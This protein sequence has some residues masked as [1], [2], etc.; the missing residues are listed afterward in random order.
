VRCDV[1]AMS[2]TKGPTMSDKPDSVESGSGERECPACGGD[3]Y[4]QPC[5]TC[6]SG[7]LPTVSEPAE[8]D[9]IACDASGEPIRP[10]D[11][12]PVEL[13]TECAPFEARAKMNDF[14]GIE[15]TMEAH[16]PIG[17]DGKTEV[18]EVP[19]RR[20]TPEEAAYLRESARRCAEEVVT[21]PDWRKAGFSCLQAEPAPA[22][23]EWAWREPDDDEVFG[24][25]E[26]REAAI[27]DACHCLTPD[28]ETRRHGPVEILV[29]PIKR[30]R[31]EDYLVIE[32]DEAALLANSMNDE[33]RDR[34]GDLCE[35]ELM[36]TLKPGAEDVESA[37]LKAWAAEWCECSAWILDEEKA[38]RV[39]L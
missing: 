26:S 28:C 27:A 19:V 24:P 18:I 35:G 15:P 33:M 12:A 14:E 17:K 1:P 6:G 4:V 16:G 39:R 20:A 3:E 23:V 2:D 21:W 9:M 34:E 31:A 10:A 7:R 30:L 8:R 37:A 22:P 13:A 36:V 38:E 32:D 25:F 5:E 11:W 29:G